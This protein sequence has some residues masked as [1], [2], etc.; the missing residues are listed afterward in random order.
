MP[1]VEEGVKCFS[2]NHTNFQSAR[3]KEKIMGDLISKTDVVGLLQD[4]ELLAEIIKQVIDDPKVLSGLAEDMAEELADL[5]EDDGNFRKKLLQA[6]M[7]TPDFK[8][9]IIKE[10]INEIGD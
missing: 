8:K 1:E 7:D 5:L 2:H 9:K 3:K 4:E 10:L 6:A